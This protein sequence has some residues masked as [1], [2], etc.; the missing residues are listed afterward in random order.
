[1]KA[2]EYVSFGPAED[3]LKIRHDMPKPEPGDGTLVRVHATSVNPIDCAV[4]SGYGT[5]FFLAKGL[6]QLP[7][8]P[9]RDVAGTVEKLGAGVTGFELGQEIY[10]GATNFATA[11]YIAIPASWA[12]PKPQ[13]LSFTEAAALPYAALT[14][15]SALVNT[16]GLTAKTTRGKRVVIPRGAGG[17]GN[18]AIQLMKAWGAHVASIVSTRNVELVRGLGADVV[19][20]YLKDDFSN[21]LHD[22]DVAFDTAFDTE[23]KLLGTLKTGADAAYVSIVTPKMQLIDQYGLDDGLKRGDDFWPR[24][25]RNRPRWAGAISGRSW[26]QTAPRWRT[27]QG[28][29]M[30]AKF[31]RSSTASTRWI[32]SCKPINS[33]KPS[34]RRGKSS[35]RSCLDIGMFAA[36]AL[37][38]L[39][40]R[41]KIFFHMFQMLFHAPYGLDFRALAQSLDKFLMLIRRQCRFGS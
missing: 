21:R 20:D 30:T 23:Q 28:L 41:L 36:C 13:T 6:M 11:E 4:R 8:I 27:F 25:A 5:A 10:A 34:R 33:V 22:Y 37:K 7:L 19:V 1:M 2:V 31:A 18:V 16:I 24:A 32:Q 35:L 14:A 17:V 29:W 40:P 38:R 9:G 39:Q 12:A 15:W 26:S 3:V